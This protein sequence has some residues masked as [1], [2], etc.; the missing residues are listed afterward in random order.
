MK[1]YNTGMPVQEAVMKAFGDKVP[2]TIV[3]ALDIVTQAFGYHTGLLNLNNSFLTPQTM[4]TG[5]ALQCVWA[6]SGQAAADRQGA[7]IAL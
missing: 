7:A 2:K 3:A 4:T 5:G 1:R 6:Q